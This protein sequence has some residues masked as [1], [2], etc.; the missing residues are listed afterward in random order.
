MT[1]IARC[2]FCG[3]RT[4]DPMTNYMVYEGQI[5]VHCGECGAWGPMVNVD[6]KH[7]TDC[8]QK[9]IELWNRRANDTYPG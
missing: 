6:Y 3:S 7:I 2:P 8:R 5:G 9:A 4:V 1:E